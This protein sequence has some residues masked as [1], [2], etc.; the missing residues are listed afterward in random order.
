VSKKIVLGTLFPED[1]NLNGDQANLEIL[2]KRLAWSGVNCEI[3]KVAPG[4]YGKVDLLFLGHGSIAAWK[5]IE[6][7]H[8]EIFKDLAKYV[9]DGGAL[10][11][12]SSGATKVLGELGEAVNRVNHRSEFVSANG[13]VGYLNTDADIE[14][15]TRVKKSV[16][17]LLHGPVLAKNPDFADELCIELGWINQRPSGEA[18]SKVD[19]LAAV[20]R[21][22]AFEN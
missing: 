15:I 10:F 17:T 19:E 5:S 12:V 4:T 8:P 22:T 9:R 16:F 20:S 6:T 13:I 21:K 7:H 1:L 3:R 2:K 14:P 18:V 11:A